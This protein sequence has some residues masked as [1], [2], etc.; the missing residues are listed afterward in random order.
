MNPRDILGSVGDS[1]A[2]FFGTK[3]NTAIVAPTHLRSAV[4]LPGGPFQFQFQVPKGG[5]Y[6]IHVSRNLEIWEPLL[7]GESS[8]QPVDYVDAD[9]SRFSKRFYRVL[10]EG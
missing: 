2:S 7:S 3:S 6:E 5:D 9:A 1:I 8:G 4:R 10:A